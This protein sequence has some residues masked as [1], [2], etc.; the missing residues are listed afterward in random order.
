M[1]YSRYLRIQVPQTIDFLPYMDG[2]VFSCGVELLKLDLKIYRVLCEQYG[3]IPGG[4]LFIDDRQ[5]NVDAAIQFGMKSIRFENY[6]KSYGMIM[7]LLI[8]QIEKITQ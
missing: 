8:D 6:E 5:E 2:S 4:C 7:K 1:N 3:L